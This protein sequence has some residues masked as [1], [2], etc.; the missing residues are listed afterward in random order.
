[1]RLPILSDRRS[2]ILRLKVKRGELLVKTRFGRRALLARYEQAFVP[3]QLWALCA[4]AGSVRELKGAYVEVGCARGA[5]TVYLNRHLIGFGPAP[6]D[7][8]YICIDT[9]SGFTHED[10]TCERQ[11]G[12]M[13]TFDDFDFNSKRL[14]EETMRWNNLEDVVR[15]V[16]AD[17]STYDYGQLPLVAFALVDVDLYRPVSDALR[18]VWARLLP[19]GTVVVDD[20]DPEN[21]KWNGAHAAYVDF[22]HEKG[23]EPDIRLGK[24]GFIAR[25]AA[26]AVSEAAS[27][28]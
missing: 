18:G 11:R 10:I 19:G 14:F 25:P 27:A 21:P 17:A 1:V 20:C 9:F 4:A 6:P 23:I 24:L 26:G 5:F 13:F 22:C 28:S 16:R 2:L 12:A 8:D 7:Y 3:D 15:V